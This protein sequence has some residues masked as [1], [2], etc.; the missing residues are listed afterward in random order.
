MNSLEEPG[1]IRLLPKEGR[2]GPGVLTQ[3]PRVS[4][5]ASSGI[6]PVSDWLG[7]A[8]A[9]QSDHILLAGCVKFI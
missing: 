3:Q 5:R 2:N 1:E 4:V 9:I 8:L 6:A 7:L